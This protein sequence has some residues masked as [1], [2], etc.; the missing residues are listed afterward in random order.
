[1]RRFCG[2]VVLL[3]LSAVA[4]HA[5][6]KK[7][8]LPPLLSRPNQAVTLIG[9]SV[10]AAAQ[11]CENYGVAVGLE[12]MLRMQ[13]VNL[14]QKYWVTKMDGGEVCVTELRP[15]QE[16]ADLINGD[17]KLEPNHSIRLTAKVT[18]GAPTVPDDLILSLRA[19]SPWLFLW[20]GHPYLMT[21]ITYDEYIGP[22][23]A[24]I[25]QIKEIKLVDPLV[26]EDAPQRQVSFVRGRDNPGDIDGTLRVQ[27]VPVD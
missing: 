26:T 11:K 12:L 25:F 23:N 21:G 4:A 18:Q 20:K 17:Y 7:P 2:T 10:P 19:G 3:L 6:D 9:L 1:M 14:D 16:L 24:R 13:G 15:V 5:G 27:A 8:S 22:N